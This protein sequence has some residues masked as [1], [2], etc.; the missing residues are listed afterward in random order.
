MNRYIHPRNPYKEKI[1][2]RALG[3]QFPEFGAILDSEGKVDFTS[4]RN[5][6]LLAECLLKRDF[7]VD[8]QFP[9]HSLSPSLTLKLNY[10]LWIQ[11]CMCTYRFIPPDW[12]SMIC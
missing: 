10:L 3:E 2:F 11:V 6:L 4:R 5:G 9:D 8:I 1:D 12:P 7:K